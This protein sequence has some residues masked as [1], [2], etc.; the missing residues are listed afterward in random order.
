[1]FGKFEKVFNGV[2]AG[3]YTAEYTF[4]VGERKKV[5]D[6]MVPKNCSNKDSIKFMGASSDWLTPKQAA[7]VKSMAFVL[8][9][10]MN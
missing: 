2:F 10:S 6:I 4:Y 8:A 3:G 9:P 5:F 1:M 7:E